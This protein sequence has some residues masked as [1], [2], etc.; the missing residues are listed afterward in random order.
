VQEN[1]FILKVKFKIVESVLERLVI[2]V[3]VMPCIVL[4]LIMGVFDILLGFI[5]VED[6][7]GGVFH[8]LP[9]FPTREGTR[10]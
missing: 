2:S 5:F 9:D 8:Y 7:Q 3:S 4:L 10:I 6:R 1:I